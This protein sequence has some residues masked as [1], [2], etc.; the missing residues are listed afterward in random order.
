MLWLYWDNSQTWHGRLIAK[1]DAPTISVA[2][3]IFRFVTSID[4]R[5][6]TIGAAWHGDVNCDE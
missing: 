3:E 1:I 5:Q 4:P 6:S 2:D